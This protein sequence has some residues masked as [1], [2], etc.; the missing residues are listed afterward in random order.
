MFSVLQIARLFGFEIQE[1]DLSSN[2]IHM[3]SRLDELVPLSEAFPKCRHLL[4]E[5]NS[6]GLISIV[7]I[8]YLFH[9]FI[10]MNLDDIHELLCLRPLPLTLLSVS[11]NP[12]LTRIKSRLLLFNIF[13][14]MFP[15]LRNIGIDSVCF[16]LFF[17]VSH[18]LIITF[19]L[20]HFFYPSIRHSLF[21]NIHLISIFSYLSILALDHSW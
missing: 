21:S 6:I 18:P 20:S 19:Y 2:K 9:I 8:L 10:F 12:F 17:S 11:G 15:E 3:P 16:P 4:L 5:K 7:T 13:H 14:S 1:I